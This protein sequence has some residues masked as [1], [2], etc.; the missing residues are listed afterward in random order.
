MNL[1]WEN[2]I[3]QTKS[4]IKSIFTCRFGT[5]HEYIN[6]GNTVCRCKKCGYI[7]NLD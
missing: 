4:R 5:N 1:F 3:E 2:V 6:W 7:I